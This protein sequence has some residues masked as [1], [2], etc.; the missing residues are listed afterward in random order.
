[1]E[2]TRR[3]GLATLLISALVASGAFAAKPSGL[4][5]AMSHDGLQKVKV[6]G[7]QFA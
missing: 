6:K 5:E 3:L 7:I 4:D 2:V 1:M